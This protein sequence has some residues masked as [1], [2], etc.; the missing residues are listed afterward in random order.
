[1][2][3]WRS[4]SGLSSVRPAAVVRPRTL[5]AARSALDAAA[6]QGTSVR[7]Q[8]AG[9]ACDAVPPG[10]IGLLL[11]TIA[12]TG[13]DPDAPPEPDTLQVL[14]GTRNA[15][16][17]AAVAAAGRALPAVVPFAEATVGGMLATGAHGSQGP[18]VAIAVE[19]AA[20]PI[21]PIGADEPVLAARL[22]LTDPYELLVQQR[23]V[24]FD[25][26]IA[27]L[28]TDPDTVV[29]WLPSAP[30]A[31]LRRSTRVPAVDGP[32][33]DAPPPVRGLRTLRA[34]LRTSPVLGQ[35]IIE[36]AAARQPTG[37]G[38]APWLAD[39][40]RGHRPAVWAEWLL[41][42]ELSLPALRTLGAALRDSP[43]LSPLP[44]VLRTTPGSGSARQLSVGVS[45]PLPGA[46]ERYF[47][48]VAGAL[49]PLGARTTRP[50]WHAAPAIAGDPGAAAAAAPSES[51][52]AEPPATPNGDM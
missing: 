30:L 49:A 44:L 4:W 52:T 43:E 20:G 8:G 27:E 42:R 29:L 19:G 15:D 14:A 34:A 37:E 32:R 10:R 1:M 24:E 23:V 11:E 41:P 36:R 48:Q 7:L 33:T 47:G 2:A 18:L 5:A 16:L 6:D 40:V 46:F 21:E 50:S 28:A 13:I 25:E 3:H 38:R 26:A 22:A 39:A 35:R 45:A 31:T 9:T 51:T 12:L 17:V